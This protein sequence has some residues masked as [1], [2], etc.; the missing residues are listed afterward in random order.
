M[1]V[2]EILLAEESTHFAKTTLDFEIDVGFFSRP[3]CLIKE[4][5]MFIPFSN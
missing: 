4:D 1:G 2:K 5:P 3:Y